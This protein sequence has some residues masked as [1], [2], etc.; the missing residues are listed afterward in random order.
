MKVSKKKDMMLRSI[1][2]ELG[3]NKIFE[4]L[5]K[6]PQRRLQPILLEAWKRRAKTKTPADILRAYEQ[7]YQFF[8][9]SSISQRKLIEF[10]QLCFKI[11]SI[12]FDIVETSPITPLGLNSVLSHVSQNNI[13]S[14][15]K[16]A[17]VVGDITSQLAI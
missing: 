3:A 6:T 4:I 16:D 1:C 10:I 7:K 14:T 5:S 15:I 9:V 13:L 2:Q 17:E 12:D 8:G 11:A